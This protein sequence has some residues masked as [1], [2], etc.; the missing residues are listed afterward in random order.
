MMTMKLRYA[1]AL[2]IALL[3]FSAVCS[4]QD[5]KTPDMNESCE[6]EAD[7]LERLLDLEAWQTFRVD[8][9]LKHDYAAMNKEVEELRASKIQNM[10]LY[11]NV[12]DKWLDKID[13]SYRKIFNADQ[14]AVYLKQGAARARAARDKRRMQLDP[15]FVPADYGQKQKAKKQK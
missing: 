9:T 10:D 12:Q 15:N 1:L 11:R 5:Q 8:S 14:W 6:I 4:A 3:F 2:P 13:E 7:R